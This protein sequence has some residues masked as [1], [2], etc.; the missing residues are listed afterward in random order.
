MDPTSPNKLPSKAAPSFDSDNI[1]IINHPI[2]PNPRILSLNYVT[3]KLNIYYLEGKDSMKKILRGLAFTLTA[4]TLSLVIGS[5]AEASA[6]DIRQA[7]QYN[8]TEKAN[9]DF[10]TLNCLLTETALA[11][12]VPPEIVKAIAEG[13]SRDWRHFNDKGEAIVT[14]DNGIGIMQI[15]NQSKYDDQRLKDDIVY[16]IQ[17]GVEILDSMFKRTDLPSINNKDRDVLEN[18]YFA[19]MAYN[20]TKPVNSPIVQATGER[21]HNAYQEKII[22]LIER[23]GLIKLVD[24]PF[25]KE[26]FLYD[27]TSSDNIRF[28]TK[29]YQFNLPLTK[30]KHFFK[31]GQSVTATT[32]VNIRSDATTDSASKG[33][34][35]VGEILTITGPFQYDTKKNHFVWYP[36][37]RSDGSTGFVASSYLKYRFKDIPMKHY[38]EDEID[39]LVDRGILKGIGNDR[40]GIGQGLTRWQ[41][42]VLLTRANHVSLE[43]RPDPGFADVPR[44]HPYYKEIA[45][46]VDTN[47]FN[48]VSDTEFK[49]DKTLTR[50][51]MAV[52]LQRLY[53]FPAA[54]IQPPFTDVKADWYKEAVARLYSSGITD[55]VTNT[56]F[57]PQATVTREQFAVFL[58]R[59]MDESYRLN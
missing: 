28:V 59:A 27:S 47:L 20:G 15:T 56:T 52:V 11:Y 7:C 10:K 14:D 40:F 23:F 55:G 37:K 39:Y 29:D 50:A 46:A 34:T 6:K 32:A 35:N 24:L 31:N 19:I 25:T 53:E 45:A 16:N 38:A 13:E 17:A 1:Q 30:S 41:A 22:D 51:E 57:G 5:T 48:G 44:N 42:V 54:S 3:I 8:S 9:P 36:V 12:N 2:S 43:D 49:P 18:W 4:C 33:R 26:D 21:N 58:V